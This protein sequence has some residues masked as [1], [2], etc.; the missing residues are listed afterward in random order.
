M[1][2]N[3]AVKQQIWLTMA[4][5]DINQTGPHCGS[6]KC[7]FI[8]Q[9]K[10]INSRKCKV[11]T[12]IM[13]LPIIMY[14]IANVDCWS[15]GFSSRQEATTTANDNQWLRMKY[16]ITRPWG[17]NA[18]AYQ[19][20]WLLGCMF[21]VRLN[22]GESIWNFVLKPIFVQILCQRLHFQ[23]SFCVSS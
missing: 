10:H 7:V 23:V 15:N 12:Q 19:Q 5:S 13:T 6:K 21:D 4:A 20:N 8:I 16:G 11:L 3:S 18:R 22:S 14:C 1:Y 2:A 17:V 9:F